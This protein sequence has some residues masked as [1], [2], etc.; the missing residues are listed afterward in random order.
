MAL[1]ALW[2]LMA[3]LAHSERT[4]AQLE[5]FAAARVKPALDAIDPWFVLGHVWEY[6]GPGCDTLDEL[7][8]IQTGSHRC[9]DSLMMRGLKL[10]VA[11]WHTARDVRGDVA[12]RG[13]PAAVPAALSLLVGATVVVPGV[14]NES[15][16]WHPLTWIYGIFL[17]LIVAGAFVWILKVVFAGLLAALGW[18]VA[19][20]G[21]YS[22]QIVAID[23]VYNAVM[24]WFHVPHRSMAVRDP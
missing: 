7:A 23:V 20:T 19:L 5:G 22:A 11:L 6:T 12:A 16:W 18:V 15:A 17:G 24:T 2:G 13:W 3:F 8:A 21:L 4:R 1:V 10:P 14:L 9:D